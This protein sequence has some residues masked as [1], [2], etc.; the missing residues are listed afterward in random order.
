MFF[1]EI[2]DVE[3]SQPFPDQLLIHEPGS[4]I[5]KG[6]DP[7]VFIPALRAELKSDPLVF[8][9]HPGKVLGCLGPKFVFFRAVDSQ[10]P[11]LL[12]IGEYNGIAIQNF[13]D[14]DF[15][16]AGRN[17]VRAQGDEEK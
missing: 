17:R 16:F 8:N 6:Q 12:P 7:F 13:A 14:I 1:P 11:D 15:R 10:K 4:G 9:F 2:L 3:M 5:N